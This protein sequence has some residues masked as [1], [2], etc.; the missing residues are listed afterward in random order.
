M[1]FETM[2]KEE[3]IEHL[4]RMG[5][6]LKHVEKLDEL[7]KR[8]NEMKEYMDN[9]VYFWGGKKEFRESLSEVARN[10][11][12]EYT[13]DESESAGVILE[14]DGAFDVFIDLLRDSFER[15]GINY[16]V[17]EKVSAVMQEVARRYVGGTA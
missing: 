11:S 12:Q 3:L 16:V 5:D 6:L 9:V 10:E 1:D 7:V 15:G 8:Y 14:T 4:N 13:K 2:S 17:S